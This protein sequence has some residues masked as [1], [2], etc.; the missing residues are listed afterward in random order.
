MT[1]DLQAVSEAITATREGL[2]AAG[3][4]IDIEARGGSL[5][6]TLR[7]LAN[8]CPE[9][10]VPKVIFTDILS[11]ELSEAGITASALEVEYPADVDEA[12]E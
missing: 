5:V 4:A 11:R 9:C 8:A 1:I 7:P 10:L 2:D 3:F 6:F 12:T